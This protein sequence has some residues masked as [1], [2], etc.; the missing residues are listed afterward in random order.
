MILTRLN[1]VKVYPLYRPFCLGKKVKSCLFHRPY[2]WHACCSWLTCTGLQTTARSTCSGYIN[3]H[4]DAVNELQWDSKY[5]YWP[6]IFNNNNMT[7]RTIT[8]YTQTLDL[9]TG[10]HNLNNQ[11]LRVVDNHY[12]LRWKEG[13]PNEIP[14]AA[15]ALHGN[16]WC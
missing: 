10:L 12:D 6:T 3:W 9:L 15:V 7:T 1:N 13:V 8:V 11:Q 14:K 16:W 5:C 4:T 2:H